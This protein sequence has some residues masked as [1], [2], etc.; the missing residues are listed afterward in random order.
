MY[1]LIL[2]ERAKFYFVWLNV[3]GPYIALGIAFSGFDKHGKSTWNRTVNMRPLELET[4]SDFTHFVTNWNIRTSKW[5]KEY[6]YFRSVKPGERPGALANL[7][8]YAVS[9][10]W[11]GFYPG[12][13]MFFLSASVLTIT[14]KSK[15][16]VVLI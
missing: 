6:V 15:S 3:E 1:V 14:A 5:L 10:F 2:W 16:L 4:S 13:Y 12:Y 11:H 7:F 8:T 9:A